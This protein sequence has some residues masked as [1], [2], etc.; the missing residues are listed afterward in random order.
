MVVNALLIR[1]AA[2]QA[3]AAPSRVAAFSTASRLHNQ[4][5]QFKREGPVA[6]KDDKSKFDDGRDDP[7][8]PGVQQ[9]L[10]SFSDP[11]PNRPNADRSHPEPES[12]RGHEGAFADHRGRGSR[13]EGE[14]LN[15][16]EE[17]A[18]TRTHRRV[19]Q[20]AKNAAQSLFGSGDKKSFSTSARSSVQEPTQ[21]NRSTPARTSKGSLNDHPGYTTE[22]APIDSRPP[23]EMPAPAEGA[24]PSSTVVNA[25][26]KAAASHPDVKAMADGANQ[27]GGGADA[28]HPEDRSQKT[29]G[30][31][32]RSAQFNPEEGKR[33][34]L[35][36]GG[37]NEGGFKGK[38][39]GKSRT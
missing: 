8:Y 32:A 17:A 22:E 29:W 30:M 14:Q 16:S 36:D 38:P 37:S 10:K 5:P 39:D 23:S 4:T 1:R 15:G 13:A 3:S 2:L 31:N 26:T 19:G 28:L 6:P 21:T 34:P 20:M 7:H 35:Y 18:E 11:Y 9:K 24:T 25:S 12:P 27:P 33:K